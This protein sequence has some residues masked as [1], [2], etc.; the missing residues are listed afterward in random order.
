MTAAGRDPD[1]CKILSSI[2]PVSAASEAEAVAIAR[3]LHD[4]IHPDLAL[5]MLQSAL[6]DVL[7]LAGVDPDGPLPDIPETNAS[8]SIQTRVVELARRE[9][10]SV[11]EI[12]RRVAAGQMSRHM[13]GS[14]AQVADMMQDWFDAGA[15]DGFV[16]SAP[17][18]PG[19]L[20]AFVGGVVPIL[21]ARGRFRSEY[22][23]ATLRENMGLERPISR[24]VGRPHLHVEPEIW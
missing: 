14:H 8:Q 4:L 9:S 17:Y 16:I 3:E 20:E 7:D 13:T 19:S 22:E 6:G 18:L 11:I 24:H 1:Q 15:C 2:H 10:L 5:S 12:A 23:G 21:Q